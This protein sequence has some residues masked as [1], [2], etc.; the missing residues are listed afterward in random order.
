[1]NY[2]VVFRSKTE[3]MKFASLLG[4][5]GYKYVLISTPRK[6]SVSCGVS[7]Q[8][9]FVALEVAKLILKRRQFYSFAGIYKM[10]LSDYI[11]INY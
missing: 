7:A 5:Y 6:I 10:E 2:L 8:I 9:D 1:M 11:K 3:T 4:S